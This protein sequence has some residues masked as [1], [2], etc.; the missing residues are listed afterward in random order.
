MMPTSEFEA[1]YSTECFNTSP[2]R[3]VSELS[4][5]LWNFRAR[6][7]SLVIGSGKPAVFG[8][9]DE[10]HLRKKVTYHFDKIVTRSVVDDYDFSFQLSKAGKYKFKAISKHIFVFPGRYDN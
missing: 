6:F 7:Y 1:M 10:D 4:K 3:T 2:W 5:E 8:I 9:S